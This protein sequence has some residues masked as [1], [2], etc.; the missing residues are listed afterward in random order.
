MT[1]KILAVI[2]AVLLLAP[3]FTFNVKSA[4]AE[5][6]DPRIPLITP[7]PVGTQAT[8]VTIDH[9][10]GG[11][12]ISIQ[13]YFYYIQSEDPWVPLPIQGAEIEVYDDDGLLGWQKMAS[14]YTDDNGYFSFTGLENPV[15]I[16]EWW[17]PDIYVEV[18]ASNW[19]TDVHDNPWWWGGSV[20][21]FRTRVMQDCDPGDLINFGQ[22][23]CP[24]GQNRVWDIFETMQVGY[25]FMVDETGNAPP[26]IR[27]F[28]N[29]ILQEETAYYQG[30]GMGDEHGILS[31]VPDFIHDLYS[32]TTLLYLAS[33]IHFKS[34]SS[35]H[36]T[37]LH[38]YGHYVMDLYMDL[39]PPNSVSPH[40]YDESYT[41]QHGLV[42][43]WAQFFSAVVRH[44][45]GA[46][47]EDYRDNDPIESNYEG[48]ARALT[49][50]STTWGG[51][52]TTDPSSSRV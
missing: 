14:G 1:S 32:D 3:A 9:D 25:W 13:G 36:R 34:E 35:S 47:V 18:H 38:E 23:V 12:A 51:K 45:W 24:T 52:L 11:D 10:G 44:W 16:V 43:G 21:R 20:Y 33:G 22:W 49:T 40:Y 50:R 8:Q 4:S 31:L 6:N 26:K 29:D 15:D 41:D 27:S 19:V 37:V 2:I 46:P 42:E 17:D 5:V 28:Y 7:T 30:I 48:S 39:S